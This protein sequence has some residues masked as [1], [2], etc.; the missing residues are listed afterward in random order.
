[1]EQIVQTFT[2]II[3]QHFIDN[4]PISTYLIPV[5][6][7]AAIVIV[8]FIILRYSGRLI[9]RLFSLRRIDEQRAVT[10]SKLLKSFIYYAVYF[11]G[12]LTILF[13]I[14]LDP[15]PI[16]AGAGIVGL[17]V[18]FGAQNLV[19][20]IITGFFLIFENQLQVGDYVEV[21]GNITGT[22]EEIGLRVTKIRAWNERLHYLSN[23]EISRVTNYN[24]DQMRPLVDVIVPFE[25]DHQLV[26]Q[27]LEGICQK[28]AKQYETSL[29]EE[30]TIYG[31]STLDQDG[32]HYTVMAVTVPD[33][34]WAFMR[35]MRK[36]IIHDF[37]RHHID[38]FYP[39]RILYGDSEGDNGVP[40]WLKKRGD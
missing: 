23:G 2:D 19:R 36:L 32:V 27:L 10:L 20:D 9:D 24:R 38:M 3:R 35:E 21:N 17:A 12:A 28:L 14:G 34:Y 25:E 5:L 33:Q 15:T 26:M 8:S 31:I 29:L 13:N 30:P 4:D 1:M 18:G 22:V 39:R 16:L 40:I 6:K 7:I 37:K 11:I